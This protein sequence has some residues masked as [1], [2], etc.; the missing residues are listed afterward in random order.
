M[1]VGIY[2]V[3][4]EV[5]DVTFVSKRICTFVCK[6]TAQNPEYHITLFYQDTRSKPMFFFCISTVSLGSICGKL[7]LHYPWQRTFLSLQNEG[8]HNDL[9]FVKL[10]RLFIVPQSENLGGF[11]SVHNTFPELT[12]NLSQPFCY[13]AQ[14][15]Q[16]FT[17]SYTPRPFPYPGLN[18]GLLI[19]YLSSSPHFYRSTFPGTSKFH[20]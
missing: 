8:I 10:N 16:N 4:T 20:I 6:R 19:A 14:V 15:K 1:P 3:S 17:V 18:T 7:T 11:Q 13:C 5:K 9:L 2:K 12:S